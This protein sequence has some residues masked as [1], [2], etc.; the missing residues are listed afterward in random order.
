MVAAMEF[1]GRGAECMKPRLRGC[2]NVPM[3]GAVA[4]NDGGRGAML[5]G[6]RLCCHWTLDHYVAN[7]IDFIIM[8]IDIANHFLKEV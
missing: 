2:W 1:W 3:F 8:A 6:P 4:L 7:S 5:L